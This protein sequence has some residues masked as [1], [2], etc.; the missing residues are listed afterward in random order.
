MGLK[1]KR[2]NR[3]GRRE[4]RRPVETRY[5][6]NAAGQRVQTTS[7]ATPKGKSHPQAWPMEG[8]G[9]KKPASPANRDREG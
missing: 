7:S 3:R 5:E 1:E 9:P 6:E 2:F 8:R 4:S